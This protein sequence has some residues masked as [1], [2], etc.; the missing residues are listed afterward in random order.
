MKGISCLRY[1]CRGFALLDP[2]IGMLAITTVMVGT[3]N[4]WR[5]VEFKC[6][7]AR[8]DARVSQFIRESIDYVTYVAYDL[9]P[10][11]GAQLRSGFLLH[12][13]DPEKRQYKD[14]YPFRIA[15]AV[16]TTDVGTP[17]EAKQIVLTLIYHTSPKPQAADDLEETVRT[18]AVRRIKG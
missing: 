14:T 17:T 11:D 1:R 10:E 2:L 3:I 12:P 18:N 8:I 13:L 7:R 9:L 4:F 5:L 16:T 6:G 15:A